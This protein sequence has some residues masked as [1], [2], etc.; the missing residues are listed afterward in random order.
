MQQLPLGVR[1]RDHSVFA[2]FVRG[3]NGLLAGQLEALSWAAPALWLWAGASAGKTHLLQASCAR[4]GALGLT[5]AYFPMRERAQ[6]GAGAFSGCERLGLVC[7][8]DAEQV[9][10]D[11]VWEHELFVLYNGVQDNAGRLVLAGSQAPGAIE[12]RLPDLRSRLSASLVVQ[13]RPLDDEGQIEALRLRARNRGLELPDET[14]HYLLRRFPRDLASL[15]ALLEKLDV[16]A[17]AAGRR[18]TIP[19]IKQ[20]IDAPAR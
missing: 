17:L 3:P 6:F 8:D 1:W 9:A 19:F 5:A 16:A 18:L 15:C 2:T 10:G 11:S 4:A 13:L 20:V 12:W 7:I 14:A